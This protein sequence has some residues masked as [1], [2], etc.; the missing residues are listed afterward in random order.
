MDSESDNSIS[1]YSDSDIESEYEFCCEREESNSLGLPF[2]P[3][4]LENIILS[5][6]DKFD[7]RVILN[8][9]RVKSAVLVTTGLTF[10]GTL[11]GRHYGGK[12]GAAVG[13]AVGGVCGVGIVGEKTL[14]LK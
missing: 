12:F 4:S 5:L 7:F 8:D 3:T 10:A 9:N 6:C 14:Q 2:D 1:E 11:I 13:G